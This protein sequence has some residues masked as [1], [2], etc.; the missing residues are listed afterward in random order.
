VR[1]VYSPEIVFNSGSG[2]VR[3]LSEDLLLVDLT[4]SYSLI[5]QNYKHVPRLVLINA[6]RY[7]Y[8]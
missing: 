6:T 3:M 4:I 1:S 5:K 2:D 7:Q 8:I